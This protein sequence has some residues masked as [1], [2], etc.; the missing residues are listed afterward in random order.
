MDNDGAGWKLFAGIMIILVGVFNVFDG[1]VAVTNASEVQSHF[2][3][4]RVQLPVT[5]NLKTWGWVVL[6]AGAVLILAGLLIFSATC[7]AESW[8]SSS[9]G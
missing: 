8:V 2:P 1:L 4:G 7:S 9:R 3:G 5:D 6:I